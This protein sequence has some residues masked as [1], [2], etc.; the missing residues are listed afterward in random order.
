[1]AQYKVIQDIEAEDKLL[2]P[3]SLRQFIYAAITIALGFAAFQVFMSPVWPLGFIFVLPMIFFGLL[4][5]PVGAQQSSEIWLLAKIRFFLKPRRRIW[6]QSGLKELVTITVPKKIERHLTKGY[7]ND[8][9][10]SRLK[11]LAAT[12]D[13]R[14]WAVKNA[15]APVFGGGSDRLLDIG[16]TSTQRV[17]TDVTSDMMDPASNPRAQ[18][19][20]ALMNQSAQQY[21]SKVLENVQ[22]YA[23]SPPPTTVSLDDA[24]LSAK[25]Q[26]QHQSDQNT[27]PH[28]KV[29]PTPNQTTQTSTKQGPTPVTATPDPAILNLVENSEGLSVKTVS[30]QAERIRNR[31]ASDDEVV[32]SL[33]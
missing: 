7:S 3:L 12:L 23:T 22:K 26:A 29:I 27:H 4:A 24:A 21:R 14:G 18:A 5:A 30:S 28:S 19:M 1:M 33:H 9:V 20:D 8:E 16:E 32:I 11:A 31:E 25:L 15:T 17:T 2:G 6:D 13:T 10:Q